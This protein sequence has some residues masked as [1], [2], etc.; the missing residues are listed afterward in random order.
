MDYIMEVEKAKK[1][2]MRSCEYLVSNF[3]EMAVSYAYSILRDFGLAEDAA[4]EAF[5][6]MLLN[7]KSLKESKAFISWLRKLIFSCCTRIIKKRRY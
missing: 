5:I 1:G 6:L 7:L 4:Q 2:D 3:H